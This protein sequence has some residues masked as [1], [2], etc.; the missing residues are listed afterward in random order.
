MVIVIFHKV[1]HGLVVAIQG[2]GSGRG[3]E[4]WFGEP[5]EPYALLCCMHCG[6]IFGLSCGKHD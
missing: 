5:V 4:Q 6:Y 1:E 2:G 3:A